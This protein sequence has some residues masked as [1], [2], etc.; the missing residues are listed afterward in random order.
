MKRSPK[1]NDSKLGYLRIT[2]NHR[3]NHRP[4]RKRVRLTQMSAEEC[5][6]EE[7]GDCEQAKE[8]TEIALSYLYATT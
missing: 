3:L 5:R 4:F 2:A 6:G 1:P 7:N 8:T